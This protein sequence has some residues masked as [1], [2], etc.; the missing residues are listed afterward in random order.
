[1][2]FHN[3]RRVTLV[4]LI[5]LALIAPLSGTS[6]AEDTEVQAIRAVQ[7]YGKDLGGGETIASLINLYMIHNKPNS[8]VGINIRGWYS[9]QLE[10]S[11]YLVVFSYIEGRLEKWQWQV[12][13]KNKEIKPLDGMA[14]S[15]WHMAKVF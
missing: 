12:Q 15:F 11:T 9:I 14:K 6:I 5:L 3:A 7:E 4:T 10:G 2:P 13:M 8:E 1:M